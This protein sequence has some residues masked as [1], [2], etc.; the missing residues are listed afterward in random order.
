MAL[1]SYLAGVSSFCDR[2]HTSC[3]FSSWFV[4]SFCSQRGCR[5]CSVRTSISRRKHHWHCRRGKSSRSWPWGSRGLWR[6]DVPVGRSRQVELSHESTSRRERRICGISWSPEQLARVRKGMLY[7]CETH[8]RYESFPRLP[9]WLLCTERLCR[10]FLSW[11]PT[12]FR[13]VMVK[14]PPSLLKVI[15]RNQD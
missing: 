6:F 13:M 15:Q 9:T 5:S 1:D 2:Q 7:C 11:V 10:I 3:H 8:A 12:R 4:V 14:F